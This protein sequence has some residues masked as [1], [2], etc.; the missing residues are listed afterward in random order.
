MSERHESNGHFKP[1]CFVLDNSIRK[2]A[3]GMKNPG[4]GFGL[5]FVKISPRATFLG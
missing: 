2:Q 1:T 5:I 3:K 4:Y